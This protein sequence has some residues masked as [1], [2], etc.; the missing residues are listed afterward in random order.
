MEND[1]FLTGEQIS[2]NP[3]ATVGKVNVQIRVISHMKESISCNCIID[4]KY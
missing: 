2:G 4:Y 3:Q 1:F